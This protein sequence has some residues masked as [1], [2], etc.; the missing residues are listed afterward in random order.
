MTR[1]INIAQSGGNNF[2]MR[3]RIIN[4]NMVIDQRNAGASNAV[5]NGTYYLDRFAAY[6]STASDYTIGQNLNAVTPPSGFQKYL[7]IQSAIAVS[8]SSGDYHFIAQQ[9]EANNISDFA[10]GSANAVAVTLSFWVR[11]SLTGTFGGAI[12]NNSSNRSYPF[13]YTINSAN[14]W[15]YKTI[16]IPGDQSGTWTL[17]GNTSGMYLRFGFGTGSSRAGAAGA[18]AGANYDSCTGG[19]NVTATSG[20]TWYITGVQLEAGTAATPFENRPYG[21]ELALC[22]R[23]YYHWSPAGTICYGPTMHNI[24]SIDTYGT[25]FLPVSMRT[26]PTLTT[27]GTAAYYGGYQGGVQ[28]TCSAVPYMDTTNTQTPLVNFKFASGLTVGGT[29]LVRGTNSLGFLGFNAEL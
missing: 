22:Q 26:T 11:S 16:T 29:V 13:S 18:W 25:F 24:T 5:V 4:G 7:G 15:E 12:N 6:S 21:M 9:I 28:V 27:Q 23:Y 19:T 3:N 2:T 8:P 20:A 1:A 10:W 17:S 14:T